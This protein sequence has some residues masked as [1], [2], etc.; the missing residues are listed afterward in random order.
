MEE[1]SKIYS[2][3]QELSG[4]NA[5]QMIRFLFEPRQEWLGFN[6]I[7][8]IAMGKIYAVIGRLDILLHGDPISG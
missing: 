5:E 4:G 6:P 3:L 8:M 2:S 1:V 7:E